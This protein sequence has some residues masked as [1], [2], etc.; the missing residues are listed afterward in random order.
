[1]KT[2]L[3]ILFLF[4]IQVL[5]ADPKIGTNTVWPKITTVLS[6]G[7]V[8]FADSLGRATQ[9]NTNLNFDDTNNVLRA[10]GINSTTALLNNV[11]VSNALTLTA[12][13]GAKKVLKQ[14]S[15]GGAVTAAVLSA[16]ELPSSV[17]TAFA[18]P[19]GTISTA[20]AVNG[21]STNAMRADAVPALATRLARLGVQ[22]DLGGGTDIDGSAGDVFY[23][24]LSANTTFTFSNMADGYVFTVRVLNTAS[25]YTVTWPTV[26]WQAGIAPTQTIGAKSDVYTFVRVNGVYYGTAVQ[27]Y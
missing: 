22:V 20:A 8:G 4:S 10:T 27:N 5:A 14:L 16:D 7:S 19:S 23:K 21:T 12:T 15:A 26:S 18:N 9:D 6:P 17:V 24:T 11:T 13:G 2:F 25:N 3:S 1:M